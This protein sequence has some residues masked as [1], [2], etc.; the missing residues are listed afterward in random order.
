VFFICTTGILNVTRG[1][2]SKKRLIPGAY[3]KSNSPRPYFHANINKN[4]N[5]VKRRLR[6]ADF[7]EVSG[8]SPE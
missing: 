4:K 1:P 6:T 5:I 2:F 8:G 7:P 3:E